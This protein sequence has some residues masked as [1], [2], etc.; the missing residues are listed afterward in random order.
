MYQHQINT[1]STQEGGK[2][3]LSLKEWRRAKG[4]SVIKVAE[5]LNVSP[6]TVS[7]WEN[8]GQKI[9][10]DKAILYCRFIGVDIKDVNFFA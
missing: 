4:F 9:P 8:N 10:V 1:L 2:V 5:H 3:V 7:K 6:S